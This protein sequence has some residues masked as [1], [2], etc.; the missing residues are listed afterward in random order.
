MDEHVLVT[1]AFGFIGRHVARRLA[2]EGWT[3]IGIGHGSWSRD[4]WSDWGIAEWH[5]I[6]VTLENL[7]TYG[8]CP[9][10]IIHCAGSGSVAYSMTHPHQDFNRSVA[11]TIAVLE[12]VRLH[13][14]DANVV[15]PSSAA[16]YGRA[17]RIPITESDP[18]Q[19]VSP[20][21][22]HKVMGE[23]LC[24]AYAENFAVRSA[25]VRL[26]SV[27]GAGLRKQLLWDA[28]TRISRDDVRFSGTGEEKRDWLHVDDAAS[29][30]A[31][32]AKYASLNCPVVNGGTG[33]GATVREIV[34]EILAAMGKSRPPEFTG[35]QREGDPPAYVA[36]I[37][38]VTA[39][40]WA[41]ATPWQQGVRDY[42]QWLHSEMA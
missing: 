16:V 12:F 1:G 2:S 39:W 25:V 24:R 5:M 29:L 38:K 11:T 17:L 34:G 14:P 23:M 7:V 6:D 26:F 33:N 42:V 37:T 13:A 20:Y 40:D 9:T 30:L 10:T 41:P 36:D 21:G 4:Q 15:Y 18:V 28:C 22:L 31:L 19:P 35:T 32:S 3:V 27:Y 8:G